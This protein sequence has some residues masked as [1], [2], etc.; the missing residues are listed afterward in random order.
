MVNYATLADSAKKIQ[1]ADKLASFTHKE[2]K[3]DPR[4]FFDAVKAHLVA[5]MRKANVELRKRG[6]ASIEQNHLPGFDTEIFLTF[7]TDSLCRV[8]PGIKSGE[9]HITA[10][11]SGPPNGYEISRKEYLCRQE[12]ACK[13]VL[14]TA[15]AGLPNVVV[16]PRDIAVDIISSFLVGKFDVGKFD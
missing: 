5:E 13:E 6:A 15:E 14:A 8:G 2:L 16:S 9:C 7:G 1:D 3:V 4:A 10:V 11:I 12:A